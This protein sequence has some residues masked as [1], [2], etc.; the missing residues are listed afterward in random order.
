MPNAL[1]P[2]GRATIATSASART[3]RTA[4]TFL[5]PA[6]AVVPAA[7]VAVQDDEE[8]MFK[9]TPPVNSKRTRPESPLLRINDD[10]ACGVAGTPRLRHKPESGV[11][12]VTQDG[13]VNQK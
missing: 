3:H 12:A 9:V 7:R 6:V 2:A 8:L 11:T 10:D 4:K 1:A 13:D 5:R